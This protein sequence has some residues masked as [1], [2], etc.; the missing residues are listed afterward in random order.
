MSE[1]DKM[2]LQDEEADGE[3]GLFDTSGDM[4]KKVLFEKQ[5]AAGAGAAVSVSRYERSVGDEASSDMRFLITHYQ[6]QVNLVVELIRK[7]SIDAAT[8]TE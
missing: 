5:K 4:R 6:S 3:G 8:S 2:F 7:D 1:N